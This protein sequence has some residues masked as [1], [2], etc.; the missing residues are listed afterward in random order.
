MKSKWFEYKAQAI[1]SRRKG[2]SI[3]DI[4]KKFG[5]P[6]ST[7]SGWLK[8]VELTNKQKEILKGKW[9]QALVNAR[10]KAVLWHN[11][12]KKLRLE[13][14]EKEAKEILCKINL[15]DKNILELTLAL[16]YL[17]EG[18]KGEV[19]GIGNSDPTVLK[20]FLAVL[21][22]NYNININNIACEL[23]LRADQNADEIKEFWAR[24]LRISTSN[25]KRVYFDKRTI[26][27]KTYP[28]YKGVCVIWIGNIAIL[29]KLI[30]LSNLYCQKIISKYLGD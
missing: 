8:D 11:E 5:I 29:R 12:Q 15:D 7:L 9:E 14:A 26:G 13:K 27:S 19:T 20:F 1:K 4:N 23:H 6:L 24:E 21:K 28:H 30:Y 25:F 22:Q 10:V 3:K 2:L 16:L 17:G 18:F